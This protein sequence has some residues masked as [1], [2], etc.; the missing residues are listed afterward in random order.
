M[1][2]HNH[3]DQTRASLLG[4]IGIAFLAM[5]ASIALAIAGIDAVP[6]VLVFIGGLAGALLWIVVT[7]W[8]NIDHAHGEDRRVNQA[9]AVRIETEAE[10]KLMLAQAE[11]KRQEA[12]LALLNRASEPSMQ[13]ATPTIDEAKLMTRAYTLGNRT[14][15]VPLWRLK[16]LIEIA[17]LAT[18]TAIKANGITNG[19]QDC[20]D[21]IGIA[22]SEGW[23]ERQ[24]KGKDPK[25]IVSPLTAPAEVW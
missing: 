16:R 22:E 6:P 19:D 20:A 10:A 21:L 25:W 11:V 14:V 7:L 18:R 8:R 17:P 23:V 4:A 12:Q 2:N 13:I 9:N 24:G 3:S 5:I 15:A 1:N